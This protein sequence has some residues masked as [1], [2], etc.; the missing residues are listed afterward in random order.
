[1]KITPIILSGGNGSRLWPQSR[2]LYPKQFLALVNDKTMLQNTL[3]RVGNSDIYSDPVVVSNEEHRFIVAEQSRDTG[4]VLETIILEPVARNTAPAVAIAAL[5]A[6]EAKGVEED[7]LL[8]VLAADHVIENLRTFEKAVDL[9]KQSAL[10]GKLVTFGIVPDQPETGYG[11]IKAKEKGGVQPVERFVEKPDKTTAQDYV[12][13]GDYYWNS[14]MFL[15]S[16]R[17]YLNEL[18]TLEPAMYQ[19]CVNAYQLSVKDRD[20]IRLD[21]AAFEECPD[22]SIDYAVMEKTRNAVVVPMA[23][24]WC[25]VGSWSALWMLEEKDDANNAIQG[26]VILNNV[27]NCYVRSEK[28][29]IAAVGVQDLV[30][31]ES[32][33]A[34]LIVHKEAVQDVKKVV[35]QLKKENRP[36]ALMHRKVYRPWGYYDSIDSEGRFQVKRITVNAGEKLSVQ[37]HHHRAEHWVVVSGTAKVTLGDKELLVTENQSTYIPI[38]EVHALENPGKIPLQLIEVQTGS[39]LGEDDIV[40]FDDLYGRAK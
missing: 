13:S 36:E 14:G 20:F 32:D 30:I 39:Y 1:M 6:L 21:K 26:D 19:A 11:Y 5:N 16:A 31:T 37:K 2:A 35:E 34:L 25:D 10:E 9:A 7:A 23:A 22:N 28:K 3:E 38:G 27:Q 33:D 4:V 17:Q 15:F 24:G 29:L 12:A 8:L 40:R 18:Q